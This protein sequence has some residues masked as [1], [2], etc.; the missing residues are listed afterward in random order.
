MTTLLEHRFNFTADDLAANREGELSAAQSKRIAKA[1]LDRSYSRILLF[2]P[3][4]MPI[5]IRLFS[6][7]FWLF[8]IGCLSFLVG[9]PAFRREVFNTRKGALNIIDNVKQRDFVGLKTDVLQRYML[10]NNGEQLIINQRQWNALQPNATYKIYYYSGMPEASTILSIQQ[11]HGESPQI[12]DLEHEFDFKHD[13]LRLNKSGIFSE[14]QILRIK[15]KINAPRSISRMIVTIGGSMLIYLWG[16]AIYS[17]VD[18]REI[19]YFVLSFLVTLPFCAS[20][21]YVR[22]TEYNLQRALDAGQVGQSYAIQK[23]GFKLDP[24]RSNRRDPIATYS[25]SDGEITFVLSEAQYSA[26]DDDRAFRF[27]Y[28]PVRG[29][30]SSHTILAIE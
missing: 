10:E 11:Y 17:I 6:I 15:M 28:F 30:S 26:L 29:T 2:I 18:E 13:D 22:Q 7:W 14:D 25:F 9:N 16:Y 20:L 27:Y 24:V 8:M 5:Y 19:G 4:T 1:N 23:R 3:L 12:S 21:V